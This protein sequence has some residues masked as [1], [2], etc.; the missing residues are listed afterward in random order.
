MYQIDDYIYAYILIYLYVI[1]GV[2]FRGY[3]Y[4]DIFIDINIYYNSIFII[5]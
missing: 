5:T 2:N 4:I 3:N 1:L